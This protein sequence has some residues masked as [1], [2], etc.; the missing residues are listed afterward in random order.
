M[1]EIKKC[2]YGCGQEAKFQVRGGKWC[3]SSYFI[4]CPVIKSKFN[5]SEC[6]WNKGKTKETDERIR[7][8]GETLSKRITDGIV[9]PTWLGKHL[10]KEHKKKLSNSAG[11]FKRGGGRGTYGWY[12][13]Y[14]CDSSWEL[15][16]VIY[17]LEHDIKFERNTQG[18]EYEFECQRF[19]YYPDFKMECGSYEEVK[20]WLDE[21]NKAKIAQFNGILKVLGKREIEPY[22]N[23]V[24]GKYGKDFVSLYEGYVKPV[25]IKPTMPCGVCG[26]IIGIHGK[27][28][29]CMG[30][31]QRNINVKKVKNVE[32]SSK[33]NLE[34]M[35]NELPLT[36]IGEK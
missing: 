26:K 22:L 17:N 33:E 21:K 30:C 24:V 13:G 23:Y 7:K 9:K 29:L 11:G 27:S 12:K 2:D 36:K 5:R 14:W 19:K 4:K 32:R 16:W 6:S 28:G 25:K 18:F 15:A 1:N 10:S 31:V 35:I 20:G 8:N 3:C 34:K